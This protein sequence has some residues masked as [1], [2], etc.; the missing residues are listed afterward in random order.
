MSY[1][2]AVPALTTCGTCSQVQLV[3]ALQEQAAPWPAVEMARRSI[4]FEF[5]K[6]SVVPTTSVHQGVVTLVAG[7][8]TG[9]VLDSPLVFNLLQLV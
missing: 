5:D 8:F 3:A 4:Q 6:G 2:A 9:A 7:Q 1:P